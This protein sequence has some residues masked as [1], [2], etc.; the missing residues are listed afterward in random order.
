VR[1]SDRRIRSLKPREKAF[2]AFDGY[3]LYLHVQ[4]GGSKLWRLKYR[5]QGRERVLALGAYPEITL[6]RARE[7]RTEARRLLDHGVDPMEERKAAK[8]VEM[9]TET[10]FEVVAR[11]WFQNEAPAWAESH[12]SRV[13]R[14]LEL[15]AFPFIGGR[16]IAEIT[17]PEV[18]TVVRRT[19]ERG[20]VE[21]SRRVLQYISSVMRYGVI[22]GRV[23]SDPTR[24][25]RGALPNRRAAHHAAITDP[26]ALGD[27]LRIIEGYEGSHVVR[28]ALRLMPHVFTRP[29]ELRHAEWIE[30]DFDSATW[31]IAGEK[32]KTGAPHIV[33]LSRQSIAILKDLEPVTGAGR[34]CFPNPRSDSRCMSENAIGAALRILG[35][36]KGQLTGHGFRATARTL[37]D[38][39]LG[40]AAHLIEHQLAHRVRDPLGRS[41]NRTTHIR[42]RRSMMQRW[43]DYLDT[44]RDGGKVVPFERRADR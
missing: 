30:I 5:F 1:L 14:R 42:E 17:A 34:F 37:L 10:T 2:K 15:E 31:S 8:I 41:Y 21:T 25:L 11:E 23:D 29:G 32:M 20:A 26:K 38:E 4:P 7:K 35:Y 19:A 18:L 9:K 22:T 3:G 12:S 28:C 36:E 24:D 33:P 13:L 44:L 6:A 40:F 27:F 39:E 43:S 16:P